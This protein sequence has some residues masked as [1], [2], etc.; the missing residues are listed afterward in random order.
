MGTHDRERENCVRTFEMVETT[1]I[2][3]RLEDAASALAT[4]LVALGV[5]PSA[6]PAKSAARPAPS[7]SRPHASTHRRIAA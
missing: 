4:A 2:R 3:R 1:K 6:E 5:E 7:H